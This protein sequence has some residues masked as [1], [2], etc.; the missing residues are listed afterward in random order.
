[1]VD[2]DSKF[3]NL[4]DKHDQD[5]WNSQEHHMKLGI[6]PSS[7]NRCKQVNLPEIHE[8]PEGN[9]EPFGRSLL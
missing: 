1:M 8:F 7:A 4:V 5:L 3:R 9:L 6:I 2:K